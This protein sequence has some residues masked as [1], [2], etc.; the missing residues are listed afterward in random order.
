MLL[1]IC[2]YRAFYKEFMKTALVLE[3]GGLRGVFTAGVIDNFLDNDISFDYVVGVSAGA[4]NTFAYVARQK[5]YLRNCMV[6]DSPFDS[7]YGIP[8]MIESH[9]VID[10][11]KIFYDY[12][13]KYNFDFDSFVNNS[14]K[15]EMVVSNIESGL[16]EYMSTSDIEKSKLIGK[17]S[18][19]LPIIT[20]P[21][22]I[23]GNLYM[24]GGVTDP[25]PVK[26]AL[27]LGYDKVVVVLTRKK[28][29][30]STTNEATKIAVRR[31]YKNYPKF[32]EALNNRGIKYKE[33]VELC[34]SLEKEGKVII[35][36]PLYQEVSRLES[37]ERELNM[38][39]YHGYMVAK[40]RIN[41]I[42]EFIDK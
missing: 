41:D 22:D 10:L 21:V 28:G 32:T 4:C 38:A 1:Y 6:Q 5:K 16:A 15:W 17:A 35:I 24:D 11:D 37:D 2:S 13:K 3:G 42:K 40:E 33:E 26:H 8:Q 9:R 31:L 14:I 7:F 30:Y 39:Y 34:E 20:P 12:T 25:I 23:D 19:S 36:R 18:C 27:D 29:N